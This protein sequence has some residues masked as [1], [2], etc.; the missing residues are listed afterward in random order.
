MLGVSIPLEMATTSQTLQPKHPSTM[1]QFDYNAGPWHC[2]VWGLVN[3]IKKASMTQE[4]RDSADH[5]LLDIFSLTWN[6]ICSHAPK[7]VM[8]RVEDAIT[9]AGMPTMSAAGIKGTSLHSDT[10]C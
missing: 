10:L 5:K 8:D 2:Q 1:V 7:E 6:V 3:N 4:D 9:E